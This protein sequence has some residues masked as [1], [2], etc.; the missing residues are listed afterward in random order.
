MRVRS[1]IGRFARWIGMGRHD[2][3]ANS[4]DAALH[5]VGVDA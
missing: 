5:D 4:D 3:I 2:F 1:Q